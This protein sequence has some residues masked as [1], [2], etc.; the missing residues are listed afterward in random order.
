MPTISDEA[1][2]RQQP[3]S[4]KALLVTGSHRSGTSALMG[5]CHLLGITLPTNLY[6]A[7]EANPKG[8]WEPKE[9]VDG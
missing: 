5:A 9:V 3:S 4:P 6:L 2:V 7:D 8:Y 1:D